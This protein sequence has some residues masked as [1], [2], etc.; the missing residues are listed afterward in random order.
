VPRWWTDPHLT[1]AGRLPMRPPLVDRDGTCFRSLDGRWRFTLADRPDAV[2]RG[3][4]AREFD[5]SGWAEIAVPG[6]WTMQGFDRPI[7][8]NVAMPF[9][10]FP[11]DVPDANPTGCYRRDFDV[12]VDWAQRR[13]I[14]H[15]GGAE[16]AM[17]VWVNGHLLGVA[18]DSRLESE[19]DVTRHVR[20]GDRNVVAI[21]VVRWSD[22]SFVEDQ[23][24]WWHAGLHR[25]VFLYSTPRTFLADVD[26]GAT[27]KADLTTGS[28]DVR[29]EVQFDDAERAD[30]WSVTVRTVGP[31]GNPLTE[32]DLRADV[33]RSR[34]AY[35]FGG[36]VVRLH[37]DVPGVAPWSA[38]RPNLSR[39]EVTLL[40][41][42][43]NVHDRTTVR[44]GFRRIEID[45]RVLLVNG[46][47]VL[48]RGVNRHD[49]DPDTGRVVTVEQ[50][51]AD[52]V[53]MK[54]FGFN[55]VRTSH[56]PND[57]RFYDLCDE[58]GMY[59][60]DEAN[61]ES[62]AYIFSLCN[63][64]SYLSAWME[65]GARMVLRDKNH[66]S[67]IMWSLGN[68]SGHG[69]AHD[70]LAA[71][72]RR[73]DPSRPVHYEG[74]IFGDW[75]RPQNATDVLCPMYP[76]IADIVRWAKRD[77][78]P[79]MP[80]IMCEYS[81]AM[82]NSN[83]CLAEYWDAIE[84]HDGLQGGFIWE[85]W[86]HGLRQRLPDGTVR[87][88]YGGDWGD[89]PNDLNFCIDGVVWPDRTPKPALWEHKHLACPVRMRASPIDLRRGV[90]RLRNVQ[91][92]SDV[93]WLRAR[94]EITIDGEVVQHGALPLPDMKP[95]ASTSVE[96]SGLVPEA[97]PGQEAFLTIVLE[98]AHDV[99]WAP[100]GFEVGWQQ[101]ALPMRRKRQ[102]PAAARTGGRVTA[103]FDER[104]GL[105]TSLRLDDR[106]FL[107]HAPRLSLWRAPT[108][109]DGLKL[110]PMQ[111]LKPLGR[112]RSF[113]LDNL[114]RTV[115]HVRVK[116]KD[117]GT[118]VTV[119]AAY[120]G[121][122]ADAPVVQNTVYLH[123]P[124]RGVVTV[125]EDIRVPKQFTDLPRVGLVFTVPAGFDHLVWCGRG[126]HESYPDRKRGARF[127]WFESS[128]TEQHVPYIVPQEHGGHADTRWFALLDGDGRGVAISASDP[129]QFSA[130]HFTAADLTA[131]THDVELVARSDI[132]VHVDCAHRGL[133][134]L[135]CGPDT[136]PE[137]RVGPGRYRFTW[138]LRPVTNLFE[139]RRR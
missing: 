113:G 122:D 2:P 96:I 4:A 104:E 73:Y 45:D 1:G 82:G 101:L 75:Q 54:Q 21:E 6:C 109:N 85:F 106:E 116:A 20:S 3:F 126:P 14:L 24:Q 52:L 110:A 131:A 61:I 123:D 95:R 139:A 46:V 108:D 44:T 120:T 134:T 69:P 9:S 29:A 86:D 83:G 119:R 30:G 26:V 99:D 133:G 70:A 78:P 90:V 111:A 100:A 68:E 22:A 91:H 13:V 92:F 117:D 63:D 137:Y 107:E 57:P 118:I 15:L 102:A 114:T 34:A 115:E 135:S 71:W 11:P 41:P 93:S 58:V 62:H 81:H 43:G 77:G 50:M 40:D 67:I 132:T 129:F 38:E 59:V 47:P 94:Y 10:E 56:S 51:R 103:R 72:I 7:Y 35:L 80:L 76:E 55:A 27:L 138:T 98:T 49:F 79:D 5:D 112:W 31:D 74:A 105:L 65:R 36:H 130:S 66:P 25:E 48:F 84:R 136:L 19:F 12:P 53:L 125:N 97:D 87:Y 37:A 8:T 60:V 33:P 88:A 42:E 17:R 18:K 32:D 16:S 89:R 28:L 124:D 128:V 121:A 127:G 39:I 23:D 64:P